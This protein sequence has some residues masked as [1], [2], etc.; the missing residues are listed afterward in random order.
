MSEMQPTARFSLGALRLL[1]AVLLSLGSVL[2]ASAT[3][4]RTAYD[5]LVAANSGMCLDLGRVA[6]SPS[7][8]GQWDCQGQVTQRWA[9]QSSAGA[10]LVV[11]AKTR[12]CLAVEGDGTAVGAPLVEAACTV[13][14][15]LW[16]VSPSGDGLRLVSRLSGLC[17]SV[18]AASHLRGAALEL[19]TCSTGTEQ[20]FI[21]PNG[22]V[23]PD[24]AVNLIGQTTGLC[25]LVPG[26]SLVAG[27]GVTQDA[28]G[29]ALNSQ[30]SLQPY[31]RAT[32]GAFRIVA[33]HSGDC[34]AVDVGATGAG[35]LSGT[36]LVQV[37]CAG[38]AA[39]QWI[40]QAQAA[41]S[42]YR[43]KSKLSGLCLDVDGGS[44]ARGT[45]LVEA[46]CST[47]AATQIW[48]MA[49]ANPRASWSNLLNLPL[50]PVS[51]ANLS[52]GRVLAW[53]ADSELSFTIPS[54]GTPTGTYSVIVDPSTG[55]WSEYQV[56]NTNHDMFCPGTA[57]L[58]DGRILIAG[59]SSSRA[60]TLFDLGQLGSQNGTWS[61][62]QKLHIGRA[63]QGT[64]LTSTGDVFTLGGSWNGTVGVPK[65]G[66]LYSVASGVWNTLGNVPLPDTS[67]IIGPDLGGVYR[68]DNHL[69]LF[70]QSNGW[71]FHAGPSAY[72]HWIDT[73]STGS[74]SAG[75]PRQD[76]QDPQVDPYSINANFVLYDA[77][78]KSH[79]L[80]LGGAPNYD[81]GTAFDSA[82]RIDIDTTHT[83]SVKRLA[84][85]NFGRAFANSVILPSG[86]VVVVGG[87]SQVRLF[88]DDNAVLETELWDP[89]TQVFTNLNAPV[90]VARNYH[91]TALLL[92][93][94]RVLSG[95]GGVCG[96]NLMVSSGCV[97]NHPDMQI[98]TP[99][100]LLNPDGSLAQRPVI[101]QAPSQATVGT[102][103]LVDTDR[104]ISEWSMIRMSSTTHTVNNDVRRIKLRHNST[105][106]KNRYK[107]SIPADSG[108]ALPGFWMLFALDA[109]GVP[110]VA[111]IVKI[112]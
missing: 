46:T 74:V 51:L 6:G 75:I 112:Q 43:F 76:P 78:D 93:D 18:R 55:Q 19:A 42:A 3:L 34:L 20:Q 32:A 57:N 33:G 49:K 28:C 106:A 5:T 82:Y 36:H 71:V 60:T 73:K 54:S 87:Q 107:L 88:Y 7:A 59:G 9:L 65:S 77:G 62:G 24:V 95:G 22:F 16:D 70:A 68:G 109:R 104:P 10:S 52:D 12:Q 23:A 102:T 83:V 53:S 105:A 92:P 72:M 91:S 63:Y 44:V 98:L 56:T 79:I 2:P 37:P 11:N 14:S 64:T 1:L 97:G 27:A 99:P 66:E 96:G 80:K 17:A 48:A 110:S 85:L 86:Q 89:N 67:D 61:T 8:L 111:S 4:V 58:A 13:A 38:A 25:A 100:Y 90:A 35:K 29:S 101:T 81:S 26:D 84:P 103:M 50:V 69:A 31:G 39:Q 45:A 30:W 15:R 108:T 21:I 40:P 47:S 41:T 94:G